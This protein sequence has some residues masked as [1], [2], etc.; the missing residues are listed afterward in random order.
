MKNVSISEYED[1]GVLFSIMPTTSYG[2][3][4]LEK[5]KERG[6]PFNY[7]TIKALVAQLN[8]VKEVFNQDI[9]FNGSKPVA[10][11]YLHIQMTT[12]DN[13]DREDKTSDNFMRYASW[14]SILVNRLGVI[15]SA[16]I[17][18]RSNINGF[19]IK[20]KYNFRDNTWHYNNDDNWDELVDFFS[21][22]YN[23]DTELAK[24]ITETIKGVNYCY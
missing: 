17:I 14:A 12:N 9:N 2:R 20:A 19:P 21:S 13:A 6:Y 22:E 7:P 8:K 24:F 4:I 5:F 3:L 10:I 1:V 23:H 16:D 11:D 18:F 15:V